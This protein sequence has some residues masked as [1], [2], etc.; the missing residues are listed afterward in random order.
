MPCHHRVGFGEN[1]KQA[2]HLARGR[3]EIGVIITHEVDA[4]R[5]AVKQFAAYCLGLPAV[6]FQGE[7]R[8]R[9]PFISAVIAVRT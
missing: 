8:T 7:D 9:R 4:R 3:G 6:G 5:E 1:G 2:E